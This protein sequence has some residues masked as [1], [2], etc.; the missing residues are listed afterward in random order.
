MVKCKICERE[1]IPFLNLG[2]QPIA[3]AFLKKEDLEKE[4]YFFNLATGFCDSCKMMQLVNTVNK[5]VMFNE[6]YA[7]FASISKTMEAHFKEYSNKLTKRFIDDKRI[8]GPKEL[9]IEIGCNDGIM[10]KYFDMDKVNLLGVEPSS[11]VAEVARR[12]GFE[13][14][15]KFFDSNLAKHIKT[16]K[17]HAK[18]IY[19]ANVICHIEALHEVAEGITLLL[20]KR[21]VFVFE[22]PYVVDIMEKNAYDQIYDEHVWFFSV[23]SLKNFFKK[24]G[25]VI[26]DVEKQ[27]T[28]GGSMRY[29][30]CKEGAYEINENV[31]KALKEEEEKGILKLETYQQ[32]AKNV[33]KSR[34]MLINKINEL[35]S[36]GKKICGYAASS[37]GTVVLNYC[38]IG[39]EILEFISDN[40]P[41]KQGLFNPGKHIPIVSPDVFHDNL[42][43][44]ALLLAWNYADEIKEK[45]KDTGIKFIIHIPYARIL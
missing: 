18:I 41:T 40:T 6:N 17:G 31:N 28:H 20:D 3:N 21:G 22:D 10:L 37:K 11:N 32:F 2:K 27:S 38:G 5:E 35:K 15:T 4:E 13:V 1:L 12:E 29:Y 7:Y 44:Y 19:A 43:D 14:I 45:E 36:Q 30:V 8:N 33:E 25:L 9:V 23:S 26:F 34:E 42:P 39:K 16:E 24:Y